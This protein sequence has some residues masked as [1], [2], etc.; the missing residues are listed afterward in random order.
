MCLAETVKN[1]WAEIFNPEL[2]QIKPVRIDWGSSLELLPNYLLG[3]KP[4][5]YGIYSQA[6]HPLPGSGLPQTQTG[7]SALERH[8]E[9]GIEDAG[10]VKQHCLWQLVSISRNALAAY[11]T[12]TSVWFHVYNTIKWGLTGEAGHQQWPWGVWAVQLRAV[13]QSNS[14]TT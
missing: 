10:H 1:H 9:Q 4:L 14:W 6:S 13:R 7:L 12:D 8:G 2:A 11:W 3:W 5:C